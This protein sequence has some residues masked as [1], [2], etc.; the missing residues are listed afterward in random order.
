[1]III[2][3]IAEST[4]KKNPAKATIDKVDWENEHQGVLYLKTVPDFRNF[5]KD[6]HISLI[7]RHDNAR[8]GA[9]YSITAVVGPTKYKFARM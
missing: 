3:G 8:D 5:T 1:M 7:Q 6:E 4:D 9:I 2:G